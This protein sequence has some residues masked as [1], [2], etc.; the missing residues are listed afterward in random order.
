MALLSTKY[1]GLELKSPVIAGSCG[2]TNSVEHLVQLEKSGAGAVVLK[3]IFEEQIINEAGKNI[4]DQNLDFMYSEAVDYI[5]NYT[6]IHE[7]AEYTSLIRDAKKALTIPVIASINCASAG[8]WIKYAK[9]IQDAGAD[10]IELNIFIIPTNEKITSEQYE[11]Q[12]FKIVEQIKKQVTIPIA[13]KTSLYFSAFARMME[14][15][16]WA[17]VNGIVMFNRFYSP[18]IDIDNFKVTAS[19]VFSQ[20]DEYTLP[21]RWTAILR[22]VLVK[23]DICASTGIRDGETAIK[24]ILAGANAVQVASALY[25]PGFQ[26]ITEMNNTIEAWMKKHN[27]KSLD[28]FRGKMSYQNI[29][30]PSAYQRIQFMKYFSGIE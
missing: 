30:S 5:S 15:L 19:N 8:E 10:A 13:V 1:L 9:K 12:Y 18:D 28:E 11:N 16:S 20:G 26:V 21:L 25:K 4:A 24:L 22:D 23:S 17:G 14:K 29:D 7:F 6:E 3:S 27:Y 2:M